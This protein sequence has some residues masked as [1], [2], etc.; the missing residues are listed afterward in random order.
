MFSLTYVSRASDRTRMREVA[1]AISHR[2]GRPNG[3]NDI[4]GALIYTASHFAQILEGPRDAVA[5][6]MERIG[7][8]GRHEQIRVLCTETG[9]PRLFAQWAMAYGGGPNALDSLIA[10][11]ITKTDADDGDELLARVIRQFALSRLLRGRLKGAAS[12]ERLVEPSAP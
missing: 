2:S 9:Q 6:L 12:V 1:E 5:S 11:A 4:T 7:R 8:D 3:R 10:A